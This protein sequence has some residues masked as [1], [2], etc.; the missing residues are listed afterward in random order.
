MEYQI[1]TVV[2]VLGSVPGVAGP[3]GPTGPKGD[4]G[5]AGIQGP[6]GPVGP[7]G[8]QGDNGPAGAD[9]AAGATG[10]AG[11]VNS[12]HASLCLAAIP[13]QTINAANLIG[14]Y[15]GTAVGTVI[16]YNFHNTQ[17]DGFVWAVYL[18]AGTWS[19][20]IYGY[21][22]ADGAQ[23]T[24]DFSLDDGATWV[25]ATTW[26]QYAASG[27]ISIKTITGLSV[28]TGGKVLIRFRAL[29]RNASNTTG[30]YMRLSWAHF[31]RTA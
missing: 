15:Q 11:T 25:S 23:I 6:E 4:T 19:T 26:E 13:Y 5:P 2:E 22:G 1:P 18:G 28:S 27:S 30:W 8:P 14:V 31:T 21:N 12:W 7:V 24:V 10:P 16:G 3:A 20:Q 9:G 29:N 17:N